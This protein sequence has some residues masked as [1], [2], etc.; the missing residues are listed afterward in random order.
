[1]RTIN[2]VFAG[3]LLACLTSPMNAQIAKWLVKPM[4]DHIEMIDGGLLQVNSGGKI[5]LLNNKGKELLPIEF[6]SI[7]SFKED[8]AL[9]FKNGSFY[10]ITDEQGHVTPLFEKGYELPYDTNHYSSGLLLVTQNR[11]FFFLNK[12]G[13]RV[14]GPYAELIHFLT[15]TLA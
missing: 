10:G 8:R 9:L 13:K 15:I 11:Q 7:T 12:E 2:K 4:Y 1:M 14:Y 3:V 5:G 6:D